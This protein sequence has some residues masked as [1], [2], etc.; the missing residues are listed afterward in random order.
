MRFVNLTL[1]TRCSLAL[2]VLSGAGASLKADS[3][4]LMY[5]DYRAGLAQARQKN[6]PLL[7]HFYT[8]WCGP[9]QR[10]EQTV[11]SSPQLESSLAGKIILVKVNAEHSPDL[12][13]MYNITSYPSDVFLDPQGRVLGTASGMLSL[14]DYIGQALRVESRYQQSQQFVKS[15]T[16]AGNGPAPYSSLEIKLGAPAPFPKALMQPEN[17]K[18]DLAGDEPA[19]PAEIHKGEVPPRVVFVALDGYCPVQLKKNR[20]WIKGAAEWIVEYQQQQYRLSSLA[21]KQEFERQPESFVP[22]LLGCDP[23][24]MWETDRALPGSTEFAAFFNDELYL[25]TSEQNREMFRIDPERYINLRH[26]LVPR[27]VEAILIR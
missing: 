6:L 13:R 25:F 23:V 4:S 9:C 2:L 11:F 14:S 10:M 15:R 17:T 22:R 8:D 26:A 19:L 18:P 27:D 21:D 1:V 24:T 20:E 16:E 5:Q 3:P 7:L 12:A